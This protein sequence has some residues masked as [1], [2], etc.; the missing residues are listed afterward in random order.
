MEF[1]FIAPLLWLLFAI[2]SAVIASSKNRSGGG[3]FLIGFLFGPF[4]LLVAALPAVEPATGRLGG[5]ANAAGFAQEPAGSEHR[6]CPFCAEVIKAEAVVCRFCGR[7]L[8][9]PPASDS[10]LLQAAL[11]GDLHAVTMSLDRRANINAQNTHGATALFMAAVQNRPDLAALLLEHGAD[12][13]IRN[14]AGRT[15]KDA[16]AEQ[17]SSG[18]LALL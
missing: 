16:A 2:F 9:L 8:P 6:K 11:R 18:V 13:T 15:P 17:G 3:W 14:N 7:D 4:G 10:E 1:L 5:L 12:P